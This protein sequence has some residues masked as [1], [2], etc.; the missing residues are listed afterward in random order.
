[1][2]PNFELSILGYKNSQTEG[3]TANMPLDLLSLLHTRCQI[4][5][6]GFTLASF[7]ESLAQVH[8][9]ACRVHRYYSPFVYGSKGSLFFFKGQGQDAC[10]PFHLAAQYLEHLSAWCGPLS[11]SNSSSTYGTR[12]NPSCPAAEATRAEASWSIPMKLLLFTWPS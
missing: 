7:R 10:A 11:C 4:F 6:C 1:M 3:F 9:F 12:N 2:F 8:L 5:G